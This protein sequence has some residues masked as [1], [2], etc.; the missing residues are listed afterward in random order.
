MRHTDN[1]EELTSHTPVQMMLH[2][3][4][5]LLHTHDDI[6]P[7]KTR[8]RSSRSNNIQSDCLDYKPVLDYID[9]S[10][11]SIEF[12]HEPFCTKI[13]DPVYLH[14]LAGGENMH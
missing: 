8:D 12:Y 5:S 2:K 9:H 1:D 11:V 14:N 6:I 4:Y 10:V 7:R 3:S 13:T